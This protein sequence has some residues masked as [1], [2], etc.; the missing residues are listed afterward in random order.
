[1]RHIFHLNAVIITSEPLPRLVV[2]DFVKSG[3]YT[4]VKDISLFAEVT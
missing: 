1:M 3:E 4:S 2:A